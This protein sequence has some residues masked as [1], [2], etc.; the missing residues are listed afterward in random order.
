[1]SVRHDNLNPAGSLERLLS[2]GHVFADEALENIHWKLHG[3]TKGHEQHEVTFAVRQKNVDSLEDI[4][5]DV[6]DPASPNY[7]KHW[8]R[9]DLAQYTANLDSSKILRDHLIEGGAK[10]TFE[11]KHGEYISAQASV[12]FWESF[13]STKFF[14]FSQDY[15]ISDK[16]SSEKSG[17]LK[18][19][20]KILRAK[21][22]SM[23]RILMDH[24]STV[25]DAVHLPMPS[26]IRAK[27]HRS[28][29][30]SLNVLKRAIRTEAQ[31]YVSPQLLNSQYGI[32]S[33]TGLKNASQGIYGALNQYLSPSDLTSFQ[34][35]FSLPQ[36]GVTYSYGNH[37]A[38]GNCGTDSEDCMEANLDVQYIMAVA[39]NVPTTYYYWDDSNDFMVGWMKTIYSMDNLPQIFSISYGADETGVSSSYAS[40][41]NVEAAKL[42]IL[43]VTLVVSSGDDG[44]QS[45]SASGYPSR[46]GYVPS[47]PATSP[48][49]T[50][51]GATM[52]PESG[53][54]EVACEAGGKVAITTGG[55]FSIRYA[56]PRYQ[57]TAVNGYFDT[58]RGT[59]LA[60]ASGY[61]AAGRG[62]PD[63][64]LLG[65]S[66]L[67]VVD[68]SLVL[69]DG[70]S[71]SAPAFAGM[72]ALLNSYRIGNSS[73][74]VGWLNPA[75]YATNGSFANDITSGDNKCTSVYAGTYG[76]YV[77]TCCTQGYTATTGWDPVTGFGS[78]KFHDFVQ[79]LSGVTPSSI[80]VPSSS[81]SSSSHFDGWSTKVVVGIIIAAVVVV[82][83]VIF[84]GVTLLVNR[85]CFK[86][87]STDNS[88]AHQYQ[89]AQM[90]PTAPYM[91]SA[92]VSR[93]TF[94][95]PPSS[96]ATYG[97]YTDLYTDV[98]PQSVTVHTRL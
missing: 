74:P 56:R 26:R 40:Q 87:S 41:F 96:H 3:S 9:E 75:L 38:D 17:R 51:V 27:V 31:G 91:M 94:A 85:F 77:A 86:K 15:S 42:G 2:Q 29:D 93:G 16:H 46:C 98:V 4:L 52:G 88:R 8:K 48:Y 44:A 33:N 28:D 11:S 83:G 1:M 35:Y 37:V 79:D 81:G 24:V 34:Q 43:G 10:I 92:P 12:S 97:G 67:I 14:E 68:Q 7:G 80:T 6:S 57:N 5:Y 22:I 63:V 19:P 95:Q 71:A 58:V 89:E 54:S 32:G 21:T 20:H 30:G 25:F 45:S 59:G 72:V 65:H 49:V 23:P 61:N 73:S 82:A 36:K 50:A 13:F 70:T 84:Y 64:S 18:S 60:P 90:V 55:G 39:Q 66:Y 47:F 62:L 53:T 69:V 76:S 78:V